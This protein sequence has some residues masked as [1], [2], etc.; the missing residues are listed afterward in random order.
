VDPVKRAGLFNG[1]WT[2]L[3]GKRQRRIR[4][5][6]YATIYRIWREHADIRLGVRLLGMPAKRE[7]GS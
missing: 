4:R 5:S 7:T 3:D 6:E 1:Y 2:D